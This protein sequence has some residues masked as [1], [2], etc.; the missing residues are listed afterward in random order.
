MDCPWDYLQPVYDYLATST[1]PGDIS[2]DDKR[3]IREQSKSFAVSD[4][5]QFN[6]G[7]KDKLQKVVVDTQE[8][9]RI[10][11]NHHGE[12]LEGSHFG[13]N[14]TQKKVS[15]RFWWRSMTEDVRAYVR[16]CSACQKSNPSNA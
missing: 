2:K 7:P 16:G 14:A 3:R 13:Q 4:G 6:R 15:A 10:V 8:R 12:P 9:D 11:A 1:Y 5:Q